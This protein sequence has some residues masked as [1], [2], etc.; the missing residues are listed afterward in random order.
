[1]QSTKQRKEERSKVLTEVPRI[2]Q[3]ERVFNIWKY[4][5]TIPAPP[6]HG[7]ILGHNLPIKDQCWANVIPEIPYYWTE[8]YIDKEAEEKYLGKFGARAGVPNYEWYLYAPTEEMQA[9]S[10]KMWDYRTDGLWF[11]NNGV[12]TY[13]TGEHF[14]YLFAYTLDDGNS[15]GYRDRDMFFSY[16]WEYEIVGDPTCF[17]MIDLKQRRVGDTNKALSINLNAVTSV[18]RAK[19]GFQSKTEQD[20]KNQFGNCMLALNRIPLFFDV[21]RTVDIPSN[22][23]ECRP[24]SGRSTA[25]P[26]SQRRG[27][28]SVFDYRST[29]SSSYDSYLMKR[30]VHDEP[31][32]VN[33][34]DNMDI[35]QTLRTVKKSIMKG[36][37][38]YGKMLWVSTVEQMEGQSGRKYEKM[39]RQSN[40]A[41]RMRNGQTISGLKQFFMP[42]YWGFSG[43][44][45]QYGISCVGDL[46]PYQQE[47]LLE[48]GDP[49]YHIYYEKGSGC[50]QM[51]EETRED[52]LK[53]DYDS[54]I[55]EIRQNPFS[56]EDSFKTKNAHGVFHQNLPEINARIQELVEM[57]KKGQ[58]NKPGQ[59]WRRGNLR[60]K[61]HDR[62]DPSVINIVEFVDDPNGRFKISAFPDMFYPNWKYGNVIVHPQ[63]MPEKRFSPQNGHLFS[64]G[65]DP[66]EHRKHGEHNDRGIDVEY[67]EEVGKTAF[68][69]SGPFSNFSTHVWWK[70]DPNVDNEAEDPSFWKTNNFMVEYI[71]RLPDPETHFED[72]LKLCHWLSCPVK[73]ETQRGQ[74]LIR[75]FRNRGMWDFLSVKDADAKKLDKRPKTA[76][77]QED[78]GGYTG[79]STHSVITDYLSTYFSNHSGRCKF[80]RILQEARDLETADS[81]GYKKAD[82]LISAGYALMDAN[83]LFTKRIAI[84][85]KRSINLG[86]AYKMSESL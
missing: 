10:D 36:G 17:G 65:C 70:F 42:A 7:K 40:P 84:F 54:Y 44:I 73:V 69:N 45:D 75:Y 68:G 23:L 76:M 6:D 57:G 62:F 60:I 3:N 80:L 81:K 59:P 22:K 82:A 21:V 64:I 20:A 28:E 39:W 15:P 48:N 55:S 34:Q 79:P 56:P 25:G 37:M 63:A 8:E 49:L 27:L 52:L 50:K 24:P 30:Y 74:G 9:F 18:E 85:E 29:K 58:I 38:I 86:A 12:P 78:V 16:V 46:L 33:Y 41:K 66:V 61:G 13:I 53:T 2:Y 43:F 67:E 5:V 83:R 14:Y 47:W 77:G 26:R 71:G 19:V 32:K 51:M 31:A 4:E 72:I 1:M 11:Y 35:S